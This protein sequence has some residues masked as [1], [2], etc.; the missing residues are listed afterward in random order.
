MI[1]IL[2]DQCLSHSVPDEDDLEVSVFGPGF[3]ECLAV[4]MPGG[5]WILVDSCRDSR[6]RPA[7]LAYLEEM[8]I[9]AESDVAMVVASHWHFDHVDGIAEMV[10]ECRSAEPVM[11]LA[12]HTRELLAFAHAAQYL[13]S[14][15]VP[16]PIAELQQLTETIDTAQPARYITLSQAR[17]KLLESRYG[18]L[19]TS[20]DSLSPSP[21]SVSVAMSDLSQSRLEAGKE[22]EAPQPDQN[23]AAVV[24]RVRSGNVSMLL[25]SDL[26]IQADPA[27]GWRGVMDAWGDDGHQSQVIK[28]AHHGSANGDPEI[29]WSDLLT[30]MP[31]G[32]VTHFHNGSVHLPLASQ[33]ELIAQRCSGLFST[34]GYSWAPMALSAESAAERLAQGKPLSPRPAGLGHVR[35][36][37]K[38]EQES[39]WRLSVCGPAAVIP[40]PAVRDGTVGI[41]V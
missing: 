17:M 3:G 16:R 10:A 33:V 40:V 38:P 12:L 4:H 5:K 15:T 23:A 7:S 18:T 1:D 2:D 37:I 22:L 31:I 24:L 32:I 41:P 30:E 34:S 26:E 35:A 6:R 19:T 11:S 21:A 13:G 14:G 39:S 28:I 8:G 25:A 9:A 29:I 20:V 27:R 36:R